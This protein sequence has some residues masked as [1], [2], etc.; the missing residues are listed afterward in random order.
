MAT[1]S[2]R[3]LS[4]DEEMTDIHSGHASDARI[5]VATTP[6]SRPSSPAA[7]GR[8]VN[9][10]TVTSTYSTLAASIGQSS[11]SPSGF[12]TPVISKPF[13]FHDEEH[14]PS[15]QGQLPI[16]AQKLLASLSNR[17]GGKLSL[18]FLIPLTM[19]LISIPFL[20]Y[21]FRPYISG[22]FSKG[23]EMVES[24]TDWSSSPWLENVGG[25][26][27]FRSIAPD[28]WMR[29]IMNFPPN[30][31][32]NWDT[33]DEPF[34]AMPDGSLES[35]SISDGILVPV[36]HPGRENYHATLD[37]TVKNIRLNAI[38]FDFEHT[39]RVNVKGWSTFNL[40][41]GMD[42]PAIPIHPGFNEL[43][44]NVIAADGSR[45]KTYAMVLLSVSAQYYVS[46]SGSD[47][48]DGKSTSTPFRT[49]NKA[50]DTIKSH[51]LPSGTIL[52]S[53]RGGDYDFSSGPF[54]LD[55][56]ASGSS[57]ATILYQAY[58]NE[59]VR[60]HAGKHLPA[61]GWTKVTDSKILSQIPSAA[62]NY[63]VQ[64][65]LGSVGVKNF[66]TMN[67]INTVG[68]CSNDQLELYFQ[69]E[70]ML[71]ARYP[72]AKQDSTF[73]FIPQWLNVYDTWKNSAGQYVV[74]FTDSLLKSVPSSAWLHGYW[75]FDYVDNSAKI[76]ATDGKAMTITLD[77]YHPPMYGVKKKARFFVVDWLGAL[78]SPKIL[79]GSFLRHFIFLSAFIDCF[80]GFIGCIEWRY[81]QCR[82]KCYTY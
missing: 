46:T 44:I 1:N 82:R 63:V 52:V 19:I 51:S 50:R 37:N 26:H 20:L 30:E 13:K 65:N 12:T 10:S 27:G 60:L 77:K 80:C 21:L 74:K 61:S 49:L 40:K 53:V 22:L 71:R 62:R 69:H 55:S 75:W 17:P 68:Q 57:S 28:E 45:K 29:N 39:L 79:F 14:A 54:Y 48:N 32:I 56:S 47:S 35:L 81:G 15:L 24:T 23:R 78:D 66:G 76:V 3:E 43:N 25:T 72:N 8:T 11:G 58:G 59:V 67:T 70:P 9:P 64:F 18:K 4:V 16:R 42:S 5:H 7:K 41:G 38:P 31:P 36:F 6:I 34:A 73:G 33:V 2:P